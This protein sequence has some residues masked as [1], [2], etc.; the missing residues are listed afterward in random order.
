MFELLQSGGAVMVVIFLF[1]LVGMA[2]FFERLFALRRGRVAPEAVTVEV[3]ELVTQGRIPDALTLCRKQPGPLTRVVE[4]ILMQ[5][6][7]SRAELKELAEEV[8]RRESADLERFTGVVGIVASVA[9][10]LG[11]LG[12]V[13]GMIQTFD[14]IQTQ[15]MGQIG[16]LAGGISTALVTTFG[17]L[18]VGIPALIAHRYLLSLVDDLTLE[19]EEAALS[20]LDLVT[21]HAGE[22]AQESE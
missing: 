19:L 20:I 1:S 5:P 17:G 18:S 7:K 15:G 6:D 10:L 4:V 22:G 16:L 3:K 14:V 8:G 21:S 2:A 13:W 9:P 11:L 12:T